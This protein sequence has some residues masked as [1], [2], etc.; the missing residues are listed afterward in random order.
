[1]PQI[2][3]VIR[4]EQSSGCDSETGGCVNIKQFCFISGTNQYHDH[5]LYITETFLEAQTLRKNWIPPLT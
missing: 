3:Q 5:N 4:K 1:M 2:I